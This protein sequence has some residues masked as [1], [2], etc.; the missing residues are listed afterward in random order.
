MSSATEGPYLLNRDDTVAFIRHGESIRT[1]CL[2]VYSKLVFKTLVKYGSH[3][4]LDAFRLLGD[5]IV[6]GDAKLGRIVDIDH[7]Y[8]DSRIVCLCPEEVE[9]LFLHCLT[10]YIFLKLHHIVATA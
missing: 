7:G 1:H 8:R 4:V 5:L 9:K 6:C 3:L 2:S 10:V